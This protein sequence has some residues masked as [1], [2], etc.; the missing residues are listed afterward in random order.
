MDPDKDASSRREFVYVPADD[1]NRLR[2]NV[3]ILHSDGDLVQLAYMV[4]GKN[5]KYMW[6]EEPETSWEP[7][8]GIL[9]ILPNPEL[10]AE[11]TNTRK[12]F[13]L[14][15]HKSDVQNFSRSI[16][17]YILPMQHIYNGKTSLCHPKFKFPKGFHITQSVNHWANESTVI[18]YVDKIIKPYVSNFIDCLDLPLHQKA[19]ADQISEDLQ[20]GDNVE[21]VH[22]EL[23]LTVMK[24]L[25]AKCIVKAY[26]YIRGKKDITVNGFI[27]SGILDV[28]EK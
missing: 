16:G 18:E 4:D 8:H 23:S 2:P 22:M 12:Y 7:I 28:V 20:K 10:S 25:G 13:I 3:N 27:E 19:I 5:G 15:I 1:I 26:H 6:K 14:I 24:S 17:W 11:S 21:K 9:E